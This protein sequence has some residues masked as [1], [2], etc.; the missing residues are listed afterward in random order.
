MKTHA[1]WT[2][3]CTM[4][5]VHVSRAHFASDLIP[6]CERSSRDWKIRPWARVQLPVCPRLGMKSYAAF[7][8]EPVLA[9]KN[10]NNSALTS[11]ACVQ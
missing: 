1:L 7:S 9:P 11:C 2:C 8:A 3:H 4:V 6:V 5:L 10:F